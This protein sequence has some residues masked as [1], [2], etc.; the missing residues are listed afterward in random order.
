MRGALVL[1]LGCA[2]AGAL[3]SSPARAAVLEAATM[4]TPPAPTAVLTAPS[5]VACNTT[6]TLNGSQ[7]VAGSGAE[8]HE[9]RFS[10]F[11]GGP[12]VATDSPTVTH[13]YTTAG[14]YRASL[15]VQDDFGQLSPT[16][17]RLIAVG[18]TGVPTAVLT[19][20]AVVTAGQ[21]VIA[22]GTNSTDPDS[23]C[24]D[25]IADYIFSAD[26]G[27]AIVRDTPSH[28]FT[29][30]SPGTHTI[31]LTVRDTFG[32][33]SPPTNR[34]VHVDGPP[35]IGVKKDVVAESRLGPV[36]VMY[37]SPVATDSVDGAV[38]VSC[39]SPSG[40]KFAFGTTRITCT[41]QDSRGSVATSTF[42][43]IVRQ[44]TTAGAVTSP[45][46]TTV[47]LVDVTPGRRVRVSA[48]GFAPGSLVRLAFVTS[49]GETIALESTRGG[50]DG[51]FDVKPK[52]PNQAS[53]GASQM[54]ALGV[55]AGGAE[56]VRAWLLT[57]VDEDED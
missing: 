41:A 46:D 45:G 8:I 2:A 44:P 52:I 48:G 20:P 19:A 35:L 29:G 6:V 10:F 13:T 36:I 43:V 57:V 34:Q 53:E 40:S 54:T 12:V 17:T 16:V 38:A 37:S 26:G 39:A 28:T 27:P 9:Y 42:N 32:N 22:S 23:G 33:V 21:S 3:G 1:A 15:V 11:D 14:G 49:T 18:T 5:T 31:T 51:R 24:G 55:D 25:R 4:A 7:S 56:F 30:L 50:S 47:P